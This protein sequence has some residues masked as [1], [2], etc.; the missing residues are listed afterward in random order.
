MGILSSIYPDVHAVEAALDRA[1]SAAHD[2][3][4]LKLEIGDKAT[5]ADVASL[6]DEISDKASQ[7]DVAL[8]QNEINGKASQAEVD[9]SVAK[10]NT[11]G[12]KVETVEEAQDVLAAR[13]D[14]IAS[15]PEGSTTGD[16]ELADI[17]IGADG[18]TYANAGDAVRAQ[19]EALND[20]IATV[21]D[22]AF[23]KNLMGMEYK[24]FYKLPKP[25]PAGTQFTIRRADGSVLPTTNKER[26][27]FYREDKSYITYVGINTGTTSK[28]TAAITADVY[29]LKWDDPNNEGAY[30]HPMMV[31]TYADRELPY[32]KYY[33]PNPQLN[34][35]VEA[36]VTNLD[37]LSEDVYSTAISQNLIDTKDSIMYPVELKEGDYVTITKEDGSVFSTENAQKVQLFNSDKQWF[38]TRYLNHGATRE[39]FIVNGDDAAYMMLVTNDACPFNTNLMVVKGSTAKPYVPYFMDFKHRLDGEITPYYS[40]NNTTNQ[41]VTYTW[42]ENNVC[43]ITGTATATSHC[44][45]QAYT[46]VKPAI[47]EVGKKLYI[48]YHVT[49]ANIFLELVSCK[50]NGSTLVSSKSLVMRGEGWYIVPEDT[51]R[52]AVYIR[53]QKGVTVNGKFEDFAIY[54][55]YP[56]E[57]IENSPCLPLLVTITDDDTLTDEDVGHFHDCLMHNDVRGGYALIGR[58]ITEAETTTLAKMQEVED[59]GFDVLPHC[60]T[61]TTYFLN[62]EDRDIAKC[63]SNMQKIKRYMSQNALTSQKEWIV[64]YGVTDEGIRHVAKTLGFEMMFS[65][66]TKDFNRAFETE[67]YR[68]KR[69]GFHPTWTEQSNIQLPELK[70]LFDKM[71]AYGGGWLVIC[72]HVKDWNPDNFPENPEMWVTFDETLDANGYPIGYHDLNE[73]IDYAKSKGATFVNVREGH[74][75]IE[76]YLLN[77]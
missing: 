50:M 39:V 46:S 41:G 62:N 72:T 71:V 18:T 53:V 38:Q 73:F 49:D 11:L 74:R 30:D 10:I 31:T 47:Y 9:S 35:T 67:R 58:R 57:R 25:I 65:S 61:Q 54:D 4:E 34:E 1:N 8:L 45:L 40:K 64:P 3:A 37:T 56:K 21:N 7:S 42:D 75:W 55:T 14:E 51:D 29:Y 44:T 70:A 36:A 27:N 33:E 17:R 68:V 76:P 43:T 52:I 5:R 60:W 15:L 26:L 20:D 69:V 48:H 66:A 12:N 19:I 22:A 24:K 16:A 77:T 6:Q 28:T 32:E 23:S 13:V 59:D 2:V 63:I